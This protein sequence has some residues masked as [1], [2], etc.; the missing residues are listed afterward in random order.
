MPFREAVAQ[1]TALLD[2]ITAA[3]LVADVPVGVFLSGGLDSA[4][5]VRAMKRAAGAVT[6]LTVG[7]DVASFDERPVARS[8]AERLGV[9][10]TSQEATLEAADLLPR[11]SRHMEE[12]TADS[13]ML[14]VYLLCREARRRFTVAMSGDGADEILAGYDTYRATALSRHYR[15]LARRAS[16]PRT[17]GG[18]WRGTTRSAPTPRGGRSRPRPASR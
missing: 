14:P 2:R 1:F 4:A 7:F 18:P 9:P 15:M 16:S 5:I 6:T 13:S 17:S 8:V 11:L 3:Q 12:P 10:F